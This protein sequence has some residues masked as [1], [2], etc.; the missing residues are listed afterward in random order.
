MILI[1]Y[2]DTVPRHEYE[3]RD[4]VGN[5]RLSFTERNGKLQ[6]TYA[7]GYSPFGVQI[8]AEVNT[9]APCKFTFQG[10]EDIGDYG[11][12]MFGMGARC[13]NQTIGRM[14]VV[15]LLADA[16]H[17]VSWSPYHYSYNNPILYVDPDG[18]NPIKAII[19]AG[20]IAKRAYK[21]YKKT[22]KLTAKSLKKAGL[23]EAV[24]I[25]CDLYTIFSGDASVADRIGSSVDLIVGTDF[26]K[27]GQKEVRKQITKV[28]P[29]RKKAL[30]ARPKPKP[31]Q[32][33]G[34][35]VTR[36]SRNKSGEGKKFKTDGGS[37]TPHVH[38]KNHND[39][40]KPNV[41]YRVRKKKI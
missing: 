29:T 25:A 26:N 34:K 32:K 1:V 6:Q 19:A 38:D 5:L 21:I 15:D 41:H 7:A 28:F 22:G 3:Y 20:R 24:D 17:L 4:Q 14:L 30:D 12:R 39:K 11:L 13:H 23:D 16:P 35:R 8:H 18:R 2:E 27:K 37:Q 36:Q 31:A 9:P 33:G 10:N 40:T